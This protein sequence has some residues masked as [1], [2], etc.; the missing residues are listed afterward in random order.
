MT[1]QEKHRIRKQHKL[2]REY[3]EDCREYN[4][5]LYFRAYYTG[6]RYTVFI[7]NSAY[8]EYEYDVIVYN[9]VD[10]K[11]VVHDSMC[12]ESAFRIAVLW[13]S[14][15]YRLSYSKDLRWL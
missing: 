14:D 12:R 13:I 3:R 4:N 7:R 11:I 8:Y 10:K 2:Y 1:K 15:F 6:S 9:H 5:G